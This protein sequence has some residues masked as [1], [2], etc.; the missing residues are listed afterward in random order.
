[1][2][3]QTRGLDALAKCLELS[4][5][6]SSHVVADDVIIKLVNMVTDAT[7]PEDVKLAILQIFIKQEGFGAEA[8]GRMS[9][10]VNRLLSAAPDALL[11]RIWLLLRDQLVAVTSRATGGGEKSRKR[12]LWILKQVSKFGSKSDRSLRQA[13]DS[14]CL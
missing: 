14:L 8:G 7:F 13:N 6:K 3:L 5:G 2:V 1:M 11:G 12:F 9:A 10:S 4:K